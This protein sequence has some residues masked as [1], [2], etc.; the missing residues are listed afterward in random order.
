MLSKPMFVLLF[1]A[2]SLYFILGE[3]NEG[4]LMLAAIIFVAAISIYQEVKSSKALAA[5]KQF[6]EPRIIVVRDDIEQIIFSEDL[7][8]GDV[9]ILEE[10]NKVPA[11]ALMNQAND[12]SVNESILT[13]QSIPVEKKSGRGG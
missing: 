13:G 4:M 3:P 2:C 5:L 8:P 7:L 10:G 6:T 1:V 12:L 9:M 11:D